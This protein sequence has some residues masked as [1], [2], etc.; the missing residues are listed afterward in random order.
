MPAK[1]IMPYRTLLLFAIAVTVSFP[2]RAQTTA[3]T[4]VFSY[5][6]TSCGAWVKSAASE[7]GRAQYVSWFRGFV[8][9]YNYGNPTRQVAIGKMPDEQTLALFIDKHCREHPLSPF[10]GAAFALVEALREP[11]PAQ[12]PKPRR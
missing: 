5:T 6:D 8:S 1:S 3:S 12:E 4:V 10:I 7:E 9:G 2:T 11:S